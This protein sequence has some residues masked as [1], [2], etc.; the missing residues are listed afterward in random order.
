[1]SNYK[2]NYAF[3]TGALYPL[4]SEEA[5][6]FISQAGFAHAELM[7]QCFADVND[8]AAKRFERANVHVS[9][10]HYPLAMFPMLYSAHPSMASEGRNLS[11][12]IVTLGK[13]LGTKYLVIHPTLAYE[14]EMKEVIEPVV[15]ENIN[16]LGELCAKHSITLAMENYPV[17]V[18]QR[19]NTLQDY[20]KSWNMPEMK[21]M[22]DTTEVMEGGEDPVAFIEGLDEAPCHLHLSDFGNKKKHLPIGQGDIPW[23]TV[24]SLLKEKG[25]TGYY[26]LE[27][28]YR[29]YLHNIP[30]KLARD[31]S[32]LEGLV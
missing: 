21:I 26:T 18:G 28:S 25:F 5:L 2:N 11:R 27:P 1:M 15:V 12:Q 6:R 3:S 29:H 10:I 32:V 24:F 30:E 16:Y 4:E 22:V 20:V 14:G 19:P 9:S 17:G 31:F 23:E 13:R 8:T 7:P